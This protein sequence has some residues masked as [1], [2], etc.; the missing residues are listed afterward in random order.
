[1]VFRFEDLEWRT[2]RDQH[3]VEHP[4]GQHFFH[5][6]LAKTAHSCDPN[7]C[8]DLHDRVMV[9]VR[10]IAAGEPISFDYETTE[11]WFTHPF[12]RLCGSRR[13]RGRIG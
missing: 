8:I 13:C 5:P 11:T 4:N 12:W 3:T 7:C 10:P 2:H 9:A 1:V 6:T